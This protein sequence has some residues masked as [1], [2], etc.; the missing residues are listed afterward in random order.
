MVLNN[1]RHL[2]P[3]FTN[4]PVKFCIKHKITPNAI[5]IIGFF[6]STIAAIGFAFPN[7]FLYNYSEITPSFYWWWAGTPIFLFFLGGYIDVIDGAVARKTG[8]STK[9]GAFLDS[10]LDRLSDAIIILGLM[11]GQLIFIWDENWNYMIGFISLITMVLISYTRSRAELE[12]VVMAGIGL[13]ER[14]DRYFILVIGYV[15][16]W[17]IFAINAQYSTG[18][19]SKWFFPVFFIIYTL[20]CMQTLGARIRWTYKWLNNKMPEKVAKIL[21]KE[22]EKIQNTE[23]NTLSEEA[24][25]PEN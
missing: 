9:F 5:S 12:G 15:I 1:F 10:T 13:M 7:I 2:L 19:Y 22:E 23:K 18:L 16:E 17:A 8:K 6:V 3:K 4:G 24:E 11:Y 21:A 14:G 25:D 20:L